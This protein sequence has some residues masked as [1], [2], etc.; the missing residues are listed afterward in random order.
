MR[1]VF[2]LSLAVFI[3]VVGAVIAVRATHDRREAEVQAE[4]IA[5]E[6]AAV[7]ELAHQGN[8]RGQLGLA[9]RLRYGDGADRNPVE[10]AEWYRKAARQGLAEA[11]ASLG[12]MYEAGDG[13]ARDYQRAA[14]W[15]SVAIR[16]GAEAHPYYALG[17][18]HLHGRGIARDPIQALAL[19]REA[20]ER[21]HGVAQFLTGS[22]YEE[23]W[24]TERDWVEAYMW[25]RLALG[26][27]NRI[28][29]QDSR[30]DPQAALDR[31]VAVMNSQ[32]VR[33]AEEKARD[34]MPKS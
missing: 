9:N 6:I 3:F 18:L 27:R 10:A 24:G 5:R 32:Q 15:Y 22:M 25:Y 34:R 21:N 16:F 26:Q 2:L 7:R 29:T 12:D 4:T 13:V 8:A 23:G 17:R 19:M 30:Y 11:A 20:A 33:E 14:E 31:L 28:L 1:R